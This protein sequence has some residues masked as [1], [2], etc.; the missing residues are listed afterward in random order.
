[1]PMG[2]SDA[3][4]VWNRAALDGG[5]SAPRTGDRALAA[6]LLAHGLI[7]NGG[8]EH[9]LDLLSPV[10]TMAA[11]EAFK[12]FDMADVGDLLEQAATGRFHHEAEEGD[13]RYAA[14]VSDDEILAARF[15]H[16]YVSTPGAFAPL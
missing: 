2:L 5:G 13:E 16:R 10:E 15:R 12:F 14:L 4:L 1:M 11:I 9:A 6:L 7:M 3:D 8:V